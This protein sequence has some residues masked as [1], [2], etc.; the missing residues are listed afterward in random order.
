MIALFLAASALAGP[1][2]VGGAVG[3]PLVQIG[4]RSG[5]DGTTLSANGAV[6]LDHYASAAFFVERGGP[7]ELTV[8]F[9]IAP[10]AGIGVG[11]RY[12]WNFAGASVLQLGP[13]ARFGF[14]GSFPR[15]RL[16]P[17]VHGAVQVNPIGRGAGLVRYEWALGLRYGTF[18]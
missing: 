2:Q 17:Y 18:R 8:H 14:E 11:A 15:S 6:A 10:V 13:V 1:Q 12:W 4:W 3:A 5:L 16:R 9:R 7:R